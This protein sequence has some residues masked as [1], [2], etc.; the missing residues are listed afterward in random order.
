M[1]MTRASAAMARDARKSGVVFYGMAG[2]GKTS[3]ALELAYHLAAVRRFRAFV[4]YRAPPEG[5][6]IALALRDFALAMEMQLGSVLPAFAMV[7]VVD[8]TADLEK[9]LPLLTEMLERTAVLIVIDNVESLLSAS[10]AWRDERWKL[11][12]DA[13]VRPGGLSRVVMTSRIRP[14]SLGASVDE[15]AIHALPLDEAVLLVRELHNL[16][17]LL[18]ATGAVT[19]SGG[20]EL[21]QRTLRMVQGHPK[22]IEL[23]DGLAADPRRLEAQL[24][25]AE[26][27]QSDTPLNAFFDE[28]TTRYDTGAFMAALTQWTIGVLGTLPLASRTLFHVLCALEEG[29]RRGTIVEHLWGSMWEMLELPQPL[30]DLNAAFAPLFGAALVEPRP[31][32][33]DSPGV[34]IHPGVAEAGH[35]DAGGPLRQHV[36]LLMK[37]FWEGV[38][39]QAA[40]GDLGEQTATAIVLAGLSAFPYESR[41]GTWMDAAAMLQAV[42][43]IGASPTTTAAVVPLLR[44]IAAETAGTTDELRTKELLAQVLTNVSP[45][46]AAALARDVIAGAIATQDDR[47]AAATCGLLVENYLRRGRYHDALRTCDVMIGL[48]QRDETGPWTKLA[49]E[50]RRLRIL[51][52]MGHRREVLAGLPAL[53]ARMA[54]LPESSGALESVNPRSVRESLLEM[55]FDAAM[56]VADWTQAL[57][58]SRE[59]QRAMR[60]R[61]ALPLEHANARFMDYG[62]LLQLERFDEAE[63]VLGDCRGIAETENDVSLLGRTFGA[64]AQV[65]LR[66]GR[67]ADA[68]RLTKTSVRYYYVSGRPSPIATGHVNLAYAL[69]AASSD[70]RE[71][72]AHYLASLVIATLTGSKVAWGPDL[73]SYVRG[74]GERARAA[75][76]S[77]FPALC[78]VV[79]ECEGVRFRDLCDKLAGEQVTSDEIFAGAA[80][81]VVRVAESTGSRLVRGSHSRVVLLVDVRAG[82]VFHR[83]YCR[84]RDDAA[85]RDERRDRVAAVIAGEQRRRDQRRGPAGDDRRELI[86]E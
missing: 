51:G 8:R 44:R 50:A 5:A 7:H 70:P 4:W 67:L 75:I 66:T 62:P 13:L 10:G 52:L 72:V 30:P 40:T 29:D 65:H 19:R 76:P 2:G 85:Q 61:G 20:R 69:Q 41:C 32:A 33:Q 79:E 14:A 23:A 63:A 56:H 64:L 78:T 21:V 57:E 35:A 36:D 82:V 46:E 6:D 1:A 15:I 71:V 83:R 34:T 16:N 25:R 81:R 59:L 17:G 39:R 42:A 49:D 60:A 47:R 80:H 77:D 53:R 86:A 22:L 3:C 43:V 38:M 37:A 24:E 45:E 26:A 11:V 54:A 58:L 28:G 18:N 84:E 48:R 9:W 74:G 12:L 27:T 55:G 73:L 68:V 31:G